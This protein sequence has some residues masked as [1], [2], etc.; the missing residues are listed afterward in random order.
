MSKARQIDHPKG[1]VAAV[2]SA[3]Q[4]SNAASVTLET[5]S[6]AAIATVKKIQH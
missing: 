4:P 5:L 1:Q 6:I 3:Y 2:K